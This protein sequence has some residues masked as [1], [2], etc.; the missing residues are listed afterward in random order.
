LQGDALKP[1]IEQALIGGV[2]VS[3]G[4]TGMHYSGMHAQRIPNVVMAFNALT[5]FISWVIAL[6]T[7]SLSLWLSFALEKD[8]GQPV[9]ALVLAFAICAMHYT[10][11]YSCTY[12]VDTTG[13][14]MMPELDGALSNVELS[15]IVA[16]S[17][18]FMCFVLI[19]VVTNTAAK[20]RDSLSNAMHELRN[21]QNTTDRLLKT[22]LPAAVAERIKQGEGLICDL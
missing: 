22:I 12:F 11:M 3:L 10:G 13:K 7:S 20:Q 1:T 18:V 2:F 9:A 16:I 6:A 21:E 15:V 14:A 5:V 17:C 4:I 8:A 19:V